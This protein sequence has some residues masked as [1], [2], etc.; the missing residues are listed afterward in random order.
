M[1]PDNKENTQ[2]PRNISQSGKYDIKDVEDED[3]QLI[4][5]YENTEYLKLKK[6][7]S[8]TFARDPE[9]N[10]RFKTLFIENPDIFDEFLDHVKTKIKREEKTMNKKEENDS[11]EE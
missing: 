4:Y 5:D 1:N 2:P 8:I 6:K 11:K 3:G 10:T 7:D 9:L